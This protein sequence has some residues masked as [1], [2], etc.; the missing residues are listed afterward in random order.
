MLPHT[1]AYSVL[2]A[3]QFIIP[4][5][6]YLAIHVILFPSSPLSRLSRFPHYSPFHP[7]F[8][9]QSVL[10][11]VSHFFNIVLLMPLFVYLLRDFFRHGNSRAV[12]RIILCFCCSTDP[13]FTGTSVKGHFCRLFCVLLFVCLFVTTPVE[14]VVRG[15][16]TVSI[17]RMSYFLCL[18]RKYL[19]F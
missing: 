17:F 5:L 13:L 7:S 14:G 12:D 18:V 11:V 1:Y 6:F 15:A 3:C 9:F 8:V 16:K 2:N 4:S 10:F 19:S